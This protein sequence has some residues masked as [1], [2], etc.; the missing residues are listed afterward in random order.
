M[1]RHIVAFR[2][3]KSVLLG[4]NFNGGDKGSEWDAVVHHSLHPLLRVLGEDLIV[5]FNVLENFCGGILLIQFPKHLKQRQMENIQRTMSIHPRIPGNERIAQPILLTFSL[6]TFS[7]I[8]P[9]P[10]LRSNPPTKLVPTLTIPLLGLP[11]LLTP[12]ILL[13]KHVHCRRPRRPDPRG[14][15]LNRL[16]HPPHGLALGMQYAPQQRERVEIDRK[17][18]YDA[19]DGARKYPND[20]LGGY[21]RDVERGLGDLGRRPER[22]EGYVEEDGEGNVV[23]DGGRP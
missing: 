23:Q 3:M 4:W 18:V 22:L 5:A 19:V 9:F 14:N 7:L 16:T 6:I 8:P 12:R 21:H 13:G 1:N 11:A 17:I 2:Q 10:A 20:G 15:Q